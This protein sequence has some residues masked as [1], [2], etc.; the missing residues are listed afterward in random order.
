MLFAMGGFVVHHDAVVTFLGRLGQQLFG[1]R[2]VFFGGEAQAVNQKPH[3]LCGLL[4]ALEDLDFLLACEQGHPAHLLQIHLNRV[5][6]HVVL[7]V[8]LWFRFLGFGLLN[9][10]L[11]SN[12]Y[13]QVLQP[14]I[15]RVQIIGRD[16]LRQQ[17]VDV[18][19]GKLA[20]LA[21]Q[22]Q[23]TLDCRG[24]VGQLA[25][26]PCLG[27]GPMASRDLLA[28][29]GGAGPGQV[30]AGSLGPW[31][32]V[33]G[34]PGA[35]DERAA[36]PADFPGAL[37]PLAP[38]QFLALLFNLFAGAASAPNQPGRDAAIGRITQG[39]QAANNSTIPSCIPHARKKSVGPL[40]PR[41]LAKTR[42]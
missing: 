32:L 3:F 39:R 14:R 20:L 34:G 35:K 13:A 5:V 38:L 12:P 2:S 25:R 1:N 23:Q 42:A 36:R 10:G 15:E 31:S 16:A 33:S 26:R 40:A 28:S 7:A 17:L 27:F 8:P 18:V 9:L 19:V 24:K 29:G 22:V 11:G 41:R 37:R 21:R 6:E 4:D 30:A